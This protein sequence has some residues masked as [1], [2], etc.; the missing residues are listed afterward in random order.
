MP[1]LKIF[2]DD[3]LY[4]SVRTPLME[5]LSPIREMLCDDLNVPVHACQFAVI[6]VLAM[7]D[8][9][10]VN[11]EIQF[12]TRPERTRD[13]VTSVCAKL[14]A[15]VEAATSTRVAVRALALDPETYVALK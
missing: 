6:P 12:L 3:R 4:P 10:R 5:A 9:P 1:N 15:L 14:R 2:V 13:L 7:P 8:L 11:A